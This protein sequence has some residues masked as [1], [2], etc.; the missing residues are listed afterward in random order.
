MRQAAESDASADSGGIGHV[1]VLAQYPCCG[2]G[3]GAAQPQNVL[4][5][6]GLPA[7]LLHLGGH[8]QKYAE[9]A[10]ILENSRGVDEAD[11][12]EPGAR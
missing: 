9:L 11:V 4:T 1:T 6:S 3:P 8:T 10:V 12:V 2:P 7:G 5:L